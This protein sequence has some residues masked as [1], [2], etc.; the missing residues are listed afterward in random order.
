HWARVRAHAML[1]S[2]RR[3]HTPSTRSIQGAPFSPPPPGADSARVSV[4]RPLTFAP[5]GGP[6]PRP[7]SRPGRRSRRFPAEIGGSRRLPAVPLACLAIPLSQ[8]TR[9]SPAM[10]IVAFVVDYPF[11]DAPER[12]TLAFRLWPGYGRRTGAEA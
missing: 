2:T 6:R 8:G 12:D 4:L 7:A 9:Q 10:I 3:G 5:A 1:S 11:G